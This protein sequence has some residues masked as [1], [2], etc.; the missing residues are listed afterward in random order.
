[1]RKGVQR[2]N[3]C[4]I[5][6]DELALRALADAVPSRGQVKDQGEVEDSEAKNQTLVVAE[7]EPVLVTQGDVGEEVDTQM[8]DA[9]EDVWDGI[10]LDEQ[11]TEVNA[12]ED[13]EPEE[14]GG[15]EL[16]QGQDGV[17]QSGEDEEWGGIDL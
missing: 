17:A 14:W 9:E 15:I 11:A 4:I 2:N 3:F 6:D 7:V 12:A 10:D 1:M 8:D 5:V 16:D 13:D